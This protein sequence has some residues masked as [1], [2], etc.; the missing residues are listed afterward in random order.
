MVKILVTPKAA[1]KLELLF[2]KIASSL[3]NIHVKLKNHNKVLQILSM[4][5]YEFGHT[6]AAAK[7]ELF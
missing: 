4:N 3:L 1:P 2:N 7:H 5:C 6:K